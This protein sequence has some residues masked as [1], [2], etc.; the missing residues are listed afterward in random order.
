MPRGGTLRRTLIKRHATGKGLA[1][2]TA[3]KMRTWEIVAW[4]RQHVRHDPLGKT[5]S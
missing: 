2:I 1:V 3:G 5:G 4:L